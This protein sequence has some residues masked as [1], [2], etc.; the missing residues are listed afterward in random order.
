MSPARSPPRASVAPSRVEAVLGIDPG[1]DVT[2]YA[3]VVSRGPRSEVVEAGVIRTSRQ[4]PLARRVLEIH[5]QVSEIL[6]EHPVDLVAVERLFSHYAHPRTA[7][8]MGHARG[9]VLLASAARGIPTVDLSPTLVKRSLTGSG[10]AGKEQ[11][12]RAVARVMGFAEP[13]EPHDVCDAIAIALV[14]LSR[15][16][17]SRGE[18]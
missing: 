6:A 3:V 7:I 17:T 12:Q 4:E 1:L 8:L 11:M 10:R 2:G 16:H 13:P 9:T 14:A 5:G 15:A 18:R